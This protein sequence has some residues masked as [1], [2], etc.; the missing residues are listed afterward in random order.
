MGRKQVHLMM[1]EYLW[2]QFQA[3]YPRQATKSF[4]SM[5]QGMINLKL[6]I[7]DQEG[8]Y[9]KSERDNLRQKAD[10]LLNLIK[11]HDIKI[12]AWEAKK[13]DELLKREK[14]SKERL[15]K[16]KRLDD[17]IGASGILQEVD[18]V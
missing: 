12:Q 4:E 6:E 18:F 15:E 17:A 9:M 10:Q 13:R 8:E 7:S 14:E 1:D 11:E 5:L 2:T 3:L 16:A